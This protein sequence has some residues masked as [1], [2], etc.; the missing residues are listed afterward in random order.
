MRSPEDPSSVVALLKHHKIGEEFDQLPKPTRQCFFR[1]TINHL[2]SQKQIGKIFC[3]HSVSL[4]NFAN[5]LGKTR[6]ITDITKM[7]EKKTLSIE[8]ESSYL[9]CVI[10]IISTVLA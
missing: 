1:E 7:K 2:F 10:L 3:F 4:T 6:Q 9:L 8:H 5:F